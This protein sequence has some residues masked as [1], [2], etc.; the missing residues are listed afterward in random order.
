MSISEETSVPGCNPALTPEERERLIF[1][2][3]SYVKFRAVRVHQQLCRSVELSD[4]MSAGIVGLLDA[5]DRFD[6]SRGIKFQTFAQPR[7]DGAIKDSLRRMDWA[8]RGARQRRKRYDAAHKALSERLGREPQEEEM[9]E[10]MGVS[11]ADVRDAS[12]EMVFI[13]LG[14]FAEASGDRGSLVLKDEESEDPYA[15]C[16]RREL[17]D[18]L[19][20]ELKKLDEREFRILSLYYYNELNMKEIGLALGVTESRVSQLHNQAVMK[21]RNRLQVVFRG[22]RP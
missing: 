12:R 18:R 19:V 16:E 15:T 8:S 9:A 1:E 5:A 20:A 10:E 21:L 6:P 22:R 4:I 14:V 17:F 11:G 2:A 13:P 7:V 3:L